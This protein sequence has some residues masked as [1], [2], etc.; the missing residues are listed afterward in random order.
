MSDETAHGDGD[1]A[2]P[3]GGDPAAAEGEGAPPSP[4][5]QLRRAREAQGRTVRAVGASLNLPADRV[6][7][8]EEDDDERLPPPTFVRGY[9]RAYARLVGLD[10]EA[11]VEAYNRRRGSDPVSEERAVGNVAAVEPRSSGRGPRRRRWLP[12]ALLL[13]LI[14]VAVVLTAILLDD[15]EPEPAGPGEET[16]QPPESAS[17][18]SGT[19]STGVR[20]TSMDSE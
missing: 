9:L 6:T 17:E 1:G 4:G 20:R 8:L 12:A 15:R 2:R 13:L 10:P 7:A 11:V 18:Q 5:Q 3:P 16:G 14:A 19:P